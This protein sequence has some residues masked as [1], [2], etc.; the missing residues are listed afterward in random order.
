M[1]MKTIPGKYIALPPALLA[2]AALTGFHETP[3][4]RKESHPN[5]LLI[6]V[7]QMQTPPEGYGPNEGMAGDLSLGPRL[8]SQYRLYLHSERSGYPITPPVS[9][10]GNLWFRLVAELYPVLSL[11]W[12]PGRPADPQNIGFKQFFTHHPLMRGHGME[13]LFFKIITV[14]AIQVAGRSN[15]FGHRGE[16]E[17]HGRSHGIDACKCRKIWWVLSEKHHTSETTEATKASSAT[18]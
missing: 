10:S 2:V 18:A 1:L 5:I 15:G 7:D 14:G 4:A 8:G 11:L 13:L 16:G 9:T 17:F 3:P 12:I 6:M